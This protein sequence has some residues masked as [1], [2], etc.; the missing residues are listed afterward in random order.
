MEDASVSS[1]E[2]FLNPGMLKIL[3]LH[4]IPH[5]PVTPDGGSSGFCV[6]M[7]FPF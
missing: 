4:D 7:V 2:K 6:K 3:S 1:S 5:I